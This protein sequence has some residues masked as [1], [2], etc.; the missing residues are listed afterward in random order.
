MDILT[1]C[2]EL[3]LQARGSVVDAMPLLHKIA[4][5]GLWSDKYS[6]FGE[7]LDECGI[8][9][10]QASRLV[11]TY[12][13]FA[14]EGGISSGE[15]SQVDPERLYLAAK[16]DGTPEEQYTKATILSRAELKEQDVFEK[17]GKEHT[18]EFYCKICHRKQ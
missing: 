10:S 13:H 4:A 9:R 18:C 12:Q 8:S 6:S 17:T 14:I 16:L 1:Q 2:R 15:L 3:F 5:E 11:S 7:Y